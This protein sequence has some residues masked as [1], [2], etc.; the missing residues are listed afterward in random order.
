[1]GQFLTFSIFS[2][3][4][5][6]Y[7]P[8]VSYCLL[9][10]ESQKIAIILLL[11]PYKKS[12][13]YFF[14]LFSQE[15]LVIFPVSRGKWVFPKC[16]VKRYLKVLSEGL[17]IFKIKKFKYFCFGVSKEKFLQLRSIFAAGDW[18]SERWTHKHQKMFKKIQK[19]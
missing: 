18:S 3:N 12:E 13:F 17:N 7:K 19:F 11:R 6:E 14:T 5:L 8:H 1:M 15:N 9:K 16:S 4:V 10:N 2:E